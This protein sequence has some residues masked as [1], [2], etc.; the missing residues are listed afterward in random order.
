MH[1]I[2]AAQKLIYMNDY[3]NQPL[4][5]TG[6]SSLVLALVFYGLAGAR[7]IFRRDRA[8]REL[9]MKKVLRYVTFIGLLCLAIGSVVFLLRR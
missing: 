8:F 9:M 3:L 1:L 7:L 4:I 6:L 2:F 5:Q